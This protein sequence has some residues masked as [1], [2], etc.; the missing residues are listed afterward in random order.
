MFIST[1]HT[2]AGASPCPTDGDRGSSSIV[3]DG[4]PVPKAFDFYPSFRAAGCRPYGV[5]LSLVNCD[6]G[7]VERNVSQ[8]SIASPIKNIPQTVG[9]VSLTNIMRTCT[10]RH[11]FAPCFISLVDGPRSTCLIQFRLPQKSTLVVSKI[12]ES[13]S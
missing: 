2:A 13:I 7:G 10:T 5:T 1:S 4:F 6:R 8:A 9:Q 3:G 12:F 11:L